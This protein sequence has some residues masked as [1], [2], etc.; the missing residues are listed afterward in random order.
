MSSLPQ[1][2]YPLPARS[3]VRA[4][5]WPA[6]LLLPNFGVAV[7]VVT[8][9]QVLFLSNGAQ[10]LFRDS[11][12]GWHVRNGESILRTFSL[13]RVDVFSYTRAGQEWFAWEWLADAAFGG[14]YQLA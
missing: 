13:P 10:A 1:I 2:I 8:L 6:A 12:T 14:A 7:F 3:P 11:D 9:L 5:K 4:V